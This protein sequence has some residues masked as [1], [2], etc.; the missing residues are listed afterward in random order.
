MMLRVMG[1][2]MKTTHK[3]F[4]TVFTGSLILLTSS[5]IPR[6]IQPEPPIPS[7]S[8][9]ITP[10]P[11]RSEQ[12]LGKW[13]GEQTSEDEDG[14]DVIKGTTE[15]FPTKSY[16]FDGEVSS[17][18]T[19]EGKKVSINYIVFFTGEWEIHNSDLIEKIVD[20][21]TSLK[22]I[23]IDGVT[24]DAEK[25]PEDEIKDL[26]KPEDFIPKGVS[27]SSKILS[28]TSSELKVETRDS[29]GKVDVTVYQKR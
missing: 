25:I 9:S 16:N 22:S 5:C 20:V 29:K 8:V 26:P 1:F 15:Y 13:Y 14:T 27:D 24:V 6:L 2:Q 10:T 12:I 21:K 4:H 17:S 23:S 28:L 3:F 19:V 11:N 18:A 7:P